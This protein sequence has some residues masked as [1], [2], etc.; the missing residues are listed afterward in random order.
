[1][2]KKPYSPVASY[3]DL[4]RVQ[5]LI[6]QV[7]LEQTADQHEL[8]VRRDAVDEQRVAGPVAREHLVRQQRLDGTERHVVVAGEDAREIRM[9]G[10]DVLGDS[11]TEV[12]VLWI[13]GKVV[14]GQ[15]GDAFP[16]TQF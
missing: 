7:L 14:E 9:L 8:T 4:R 5:E 1:M 10:Q 15:N 11:V 2:A 13:A 12:F 6:N 3:S 16:R